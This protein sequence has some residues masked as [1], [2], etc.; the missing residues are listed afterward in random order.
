M[1][2]NTCVSAPSMP[3]PATIVCPWY[4]MTPVAIAAMEPV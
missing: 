2:S 4:W 3:R 1:V